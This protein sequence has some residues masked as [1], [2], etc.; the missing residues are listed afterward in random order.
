MKKFISLFIALVM[1][2][3]ISTISGVIAFADDVIN[4]A[5]NVIGGRLEFQND[6]DNPWV[7]DTT[8]IG[9]YCAAS[10]IRGKDNTSTTLSATLTFAENEAISFWWRV[11]S[12]NKYDTFTFSVDGKDLVTISGNIY[13][14][15]KLYPIPAGEHVVSW[16]YTKDS[17]Y[18][19]YNDSGYVD[20]VEILTYRENTDI[21]DY[22]NSRSE[23]LE[24]E[25]DPAYPWTSYEY[26]TRM[27][28]SNI[29]GKN[30]TS[31][32]VTTHTYLKANQIVSFTWAVNSEEHWDRLIFEVNG[33]EV[34]SIS[35]NVISRTERYVVPKDGEYTLRWIYSKDAKNDIGDDC[36]KIG[37]VRI[38][39]SVDVTGVIIVKKALVRVG[40]QI[41][42]ASSI[43]PS[44]ATNRD[45]TWSSSD[46]SIATID[47]TGLVK[48]VSE[49]VCTLTAT[50]VEGGFT[51]TCTLTVNEFEGGRTF[52]VNGNSGNDKNNG[53]SAGAAV[54]TLAK[55]VALARAS[56]LDNATIILLS[57]VKVKEPTIIS[58]ININIIV[59]ASNKHYTISRETGYRG[60]IFKVSSGAGL[61][62]GNSATD[63]SISIGKSEAD[64]PAIFVES[65]EA[66]MA[67]NVSIENNK[68]TT[69]GAGVYVKNGSFVMVGGTI[70]GNISERY[71]AGIYNENG[72]I[73]LAGGNVTGNNAKLDAGGV[74]VKNTAEATIN[75]DV[76][77][78][79]LSDG[80][81][82]DVF[83]EEP[84][85]PEEPEEPGEHVNAIAFVSDSDSE[86]IGKIISFDLYDCAVGKSLA[87]PYR[88]SAGESTDGQVVYGYTEDNIFFTYDISAEVISPAE[89][90]VDYTVLDMTYCFDCVKMYALVSNDDNDRFLATVNLDD[91]TLS[92][93]TEIK[94]T[95]Q[96]G[97]M[98]T[99]SADKEG[100]LYGLSGGDNAGLFAV[101]E[102]GTAT[103][104]GYTGVE[105]YYFQSA[106]FD[107]SNGTLYWAQCSENGCGI[108]KVDTAT[109]EVTKVG[110]VLDDNT[111]LTA[112]GIVYEINTEEEHFSKD[113]KYVYKLNKDGSAVIT[114]LQ[115]GA[116]A[117]FP[118]CEGSSDT[119][120]AEIPDKVDG[121]P[122]KALGKYAFAEKSDAKPKLGKVVIS[123]S[124]EEI[125][126]GSFRGCSELE[127]VQFG[128]NEEVIG[129]YAFYQCTSLDEI[130]IPESVETIKYGAFAGCSNLSKIVIN[131][132]N[133]VFED[134]M[135]FEAQDDLTIYG[136]YPSTV[137]DYAKA[138]EINFADIGEY[139]PPVVIGV[140]DGVTYL[141][142]E[143]PEG[144]SITWESAYETTC[145]LNGGEYTA[146][147]PITEEGEYVFTVS[148][149]RTEV[150]V[151]FI[152]KS[153]KVMKGDFD[154][155][156]EIT[157]A[158]ALAALRIAAK[159]VEE[160]AEA[161]EI[162][163]IDADEHV[164]VA[165]ALAILRVAA[166]LTDSL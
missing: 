65:G 156:G 67:G 137:Y 87:I 153:D 91:G 144:V 11:S 100:N 88:V 163:D 154:K 160:D 158:D 5:V 66:F 81:N 7:Y 43:R 114:G 59:D 33:E 120:Q 159:L 140:E 149:G 39:D 23:T 111:E 94:I 103:L 93:V 95:E 37:S 68:S 96:T 41:T 135:F 74:Y 124:I 60:E 128:G 40:D 142:K 14:E 166:K 30:E 25:N 129:E 105:C 164:T 92:D 83:I 99:I 48:G 122:V 21:N 108:Y 12:E 126:Y 32:A 64:A 125:G 1:C 58:D 38:S 78:D 18:A 42:L 8:V 80:E 97:P 53:R 20:D 107:R 112:F 28:K 16:T 10:N 116:R 157:V 101:S 151:S 50:T 102:D 146:G 51:A 148:D 52:Y 24:F 165:D 152:I 98:M 70:S 49:G 44:T 76:V 6:E 54:R 147:T 27:V 4:Q 46:P 113:G 61:Y 155:D 161:V 130:T 141:L 2:V 36:A 162:G 79:N 35:G 89:T 86:E 17:S 19:M 115:D 131:N 73:L 15:N 106:S 134:Y 3:S 22:M 63:N 110:T 117:L 150:T 143:V 13:W 85:D 57:D 26:N 77:V 136:N 75:E 139:N 55:A 71:G 72:S 90:P 132:D 138:N 118:L 104:V 69:S 123:A 127:D 121:A 145:S 119:Y 9:R 62:L 31:T 133:T 47:N 84:N 82:K 29:E 45:V 56:D 109:A 34:S